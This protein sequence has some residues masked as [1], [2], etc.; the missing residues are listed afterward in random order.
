MHHGRAETDYYAWMRD[1]D[2][3]ELLR[4]LAA[5][6]AYYDA[7]SRRTEPL[8]A[9]L[10]AEA[11]AR[12]PAG[13]EYS[14]AW[15]RGGWAYRTRTAP[16]AEGPQLLRSRPGEA[17]EQVV[18]DENELAAATGYA[19][20]GCREPSP[21]GR[22]L[23]WSADTSG[24]EIYAL[25]I[26]DLGSGEDLP[27]VIER[28]YPG[29]AW[30]ADSQFLFYLVPD[31]L[32][33]PFQVRRHRVGTSAA[34]DVLV[35]AE[36]DARFELTLAAARSGELILITAASRDTTQVWVI[37]AAGPLAVPV[38]AGPRRRGMEYRADHAAGPAGGPGELYLVTDDGAA[39]FRL[40]RAPVPA[41]SAGLAWSLVTTPAAAPSRAD[42]RL[43]GCDVFADC[44][45]LTL[46]RDGAPLL[47]V[48]DHDGGTI[49]EILP[50]GPAATIAVEHAED[51]GG[52][53]VLISEQSLI[54]P[55][56]WSRLDLATG[57]RTP[58]WRQ[59]VPGHDPARYRTER[60]WAAAPDGTQIPV[61]LARRAGVALDG[62]APCLL[63]GYGAYESCED[64]LFDL[65]LPSLLDRGVVYAIAHVRGGGECGRAW[66]Q[67]GRLRAKP[68]TFSDFIAVADWL[69]GDVPGSRP[70]VDGTRIACRGLSAGGLLAGA[71]YSRAPQRWRAVVAEVPFVDCVASMLDPSIPLTVNEWDEWGDPRDPGDYACLRS[72]SP[73]DNPPAGP[74]PA[75]LT[76][77]TLHDPRVGIHEPARWVARL[78]ETDTAGSVILLRAEL[79]AG[80]HTGPS[81][82]RGRLR[83]EAEIQAF[84]L[85]ALG[86]ND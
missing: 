54:T 78:R 4:Y 9:R 43:L 6:R 17:G 56:R 3:P 74:R 11:Q 29:V 63:Y 40:A 20:A 25:R 15:T 46:R 31:V 28:S 21:D 5:E 24:A 13:P 16:D 77:G 52:G 69:A 42:T 72:Y 68:T 7:C 18:L 26:R 2:A 67:Q 41:G 50:A 86:I 79:G 47:T 73:C 12:L 27:E 64:P 22:L 75:L 1:H 62:T 84:V 23:A 58:V 71:V 48:T 30:S 55:P 34:A 32:N 53:S 8:A 35:L 45:L 33:R 83:Y 70:L 49:R 81:G 85:D 61:T 39:E 65:S 36:P 10:F 37:P 66:W 19:E 57:E 59:Q 51:Y 82:R 38:P 14:A 60:L 80:A 44:L 76:T